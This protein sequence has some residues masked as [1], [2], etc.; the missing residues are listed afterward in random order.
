MYPK[1]WVDEVVLKR[2][3]L[4]DLLVNHI[5]SN[6]PAIPAL[7]QARVTTAAKVVLTLWSALSSH[8]GFVPKKN[9]NDLIDSGLWYVPMCG[10][11]QQFIPFL[12]YQ[13]SYIFAKSEDQ[14]ELPERP[15]W[16]HHKS[17]LVLTGQLGRIF[18][19]RCFGVSLTNIE[20]RNTVLH[21]IKKG[22]P[23]MGEHHLVKNCHAMK[24]R[25]EVIQETPPEALRE[26]RR[27][28][29]E[30]FPRGIQLSHWEG[31]TDY[32]S[33][34]DHASFDYPRSRGGNLGHLRLY[35]EGRFT[36]RE[37]GLSLN[38]LPVSA[39]ISPDQ[40]G[41]VYWRP[42]S[43]ETLEYRLP[44][45]TRSE[46]YQ[47]FQRYSLYFHEE[48]GMAKIKPIFEPLKVRMISAGDIYSNGLYSSLQKLLWKGLQ[49][50]PQFTLTGESVTTRHIQFV[51][52]MTSIQGLHGLYEK[53]VS[54]DYSA[55][56]DSMH[57]DATVA[58]IEEIGADA[59]TRKVLERGLTDTLLDFS[60][61]KI[62][63]GELPDPFLMTNGQLMGCVF[64]FPILCIVN[65]A[66]YRMALEKC[67]G[68]TFKLVELPALC[69]GDDILFKANDDLY[70]KWNHAIAGVGFKKSVG[71]NYYSSRTA[72][73]NS[74]YFR[75]RPSGFESVPYL[76][77]GWV[78]GVSKSGQQGDKRDDGKEEDESLVSI[79]PKV[80]KTI[81]DWSYPAGPH[82]EREESRRAKIIERFR[83]EILS[84]NSS[85]ISETR[86]SLGCGPD[87]LGLEDNVDVKYESMSFYS[88]LYRGYDQ[89]L[90][91]VSHPCTLAPWKHLKR[92]P[93]GDEDLLECNENFLDFFNMNR[94]KTEKKF[95]IGF[96]PDLVGPRCYEEYISERRHYAGN[97]E[98]VTGRRWVRPRTA[99]TPEE[100]YR[101]LENKFEIARFNSY[102]RTR[103]D[104]QVTLGALSNTHSRVVPLNVDGYTLSEWSLPDNLYSRLCLM[105]GRE[106]ID[107]SVEVLR[108][109]NPVLDYI[110]RFRG[111]QNT[112]PDDGVAGS[113]ETETGM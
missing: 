19:S 83:K 40:L 65:M 43:N 41:A 17:G 111:Y 32:T 108:R 107:L 106:D 90:G 86:V 84:W 78:T 29:R 103:C 76:N 102:I 113:A 7:F 72:V 109:S 110:G 91:L 28:A 23:Q 3:D 81:S 33:M 80:E 12:K 74:Q 4:E 2:K 93:F 30:I 98:Q 18:Y 53:Y 20:W 88:N 52:N 38:E 46:S 56:T 11:E 104:S 96:D 22:L 89:T 69:N 13:L 25:L 77:L 31:A 37:G 70:E 54:G 44:S 5:T 79:R 57:K 14:E 26:V 95:G 50:F 27:T 48:K 73:I 34:S 67:T 42:S 97:W 61:I 24:A 94:I 105:S 9:F 58:A 63:S 47:Q 16:M 59:M 35:D 99:R 64:S 112:H 66:V 92:T 101:G 87:G 82:R 1:T 75:V 49:K 55:A 21:G 60:S 8:F 6:N 71:K 85:R 68:R 15:E 39:R 100:V 62:E 45:W 51:K 10:E 36:F